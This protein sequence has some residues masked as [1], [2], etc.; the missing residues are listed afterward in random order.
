MGDIILDLG[1]EVNVLP[2]KIWECMGEPTLG[3]SLIQLKLANQHRVVPIVRLKGILVDLYGVCTM[4]YFE[5]IDIVDNIAPYP[6]LLGPDWA[7][8]NKVI[9]NLKAQKLIFKPVNYRVIS[10]LDPS[11]CETYVE[12]VTENFI[13]E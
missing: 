1:Y 8:E 2:K 4:E 7:F 12:L 10:P 13:I 9:I 6:A 5:V 3:Y 11:E